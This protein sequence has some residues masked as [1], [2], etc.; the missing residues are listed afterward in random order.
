MRNIRRADGVALFGEKE[1]LLE[2]RGKASSGRSPMA[3]E[4]GSEY[5]VVCG[6]FCGET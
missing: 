3:H 5:P 1:V 4:V 6:L 2:V